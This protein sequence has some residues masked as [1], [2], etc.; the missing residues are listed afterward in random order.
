MSKSTDLSRAKAII[1]AVSTLLQEFEGAKTSPNV[2][3]MTY[4]DFDIIKTSFPYLVKG[5]VIVY[6]KQ[7]LQV[8]FTAQKGT[9]GLALSFHTD[10][11]EDYNESPQP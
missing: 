10:F 8:I 4:K 2:I 11:V 5:E 3:F 6:N 7:R 1:K 9:I